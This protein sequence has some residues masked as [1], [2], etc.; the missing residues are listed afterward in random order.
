MNTIGVLRSDWSANNSLTP[1]RI[2][3]CLY[4]LPRKGKKALPSEFKF[5]YQQLYGMTNDILSF[6]NV[7]G[8]YHC[9]NA[10][11][12]H[13]YICNLI[14]AYGLI[15]KKDLVLKFDEGKTAFVSVPPLDIFNYIKDQFQRKKNSCLTYLGIEQFPT[16]DKDKDTLSRD[17]WSTNSSIPFH[18]S[19][20]EDMNEFMNRKSCLSM[21][22]MYPYLSI[23]YNNI[24]SK[25]RKKQDDL[26]RSDSTT[27][28]NLPIMQSNNKTFS[29]IYPI[30]TTTDFHFYNYSHF[31][32]DGT[33]T[34]Y[35]GDDEGSNTEDTVPTIHHSSKVRL[36][37]EANAKCSFF[38]VFNS[39]IIHSGSA[40]SFSSPTDFSTTNNPRFFTYVSRDGNDGSDAKNN[41]NKIDKVSFNFCN[42][43]KCKICKE[44]LNI[45]KTEEIVVNAYEEM[46]KRNNE[47]NKPAMKN[48]KQY[49]GRNYICGDLH[50]LGWAVYKG[51]PLCTKPQLTLLKNSVLELVERSSTGSTWMQIDKGRKICNIDRLNTGHL[52]AQ[53]SI[54]LND[55]KVFRN[56]AYEQL[57]R[58]DKFANSSFYGSSIIIHHGPCKEQEP[59][60][61]IFKDEVLVDLPST[62][63]LS[64]TGNTNKG[65]DSHDDENSNEEQ[66]SDNIDNT[67]RRKSRRRLSPSRRNKK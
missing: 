20:V 26:S 58:I 59:H 24:F 65:N 67:T 4:I 2:E 21:N 31:L 40:S 39:S 32:F 37:L 55:L 62:R 56:F 11:L 42:K 38:V 16:D 41:V 51:V 63:V 18:Q 35:K 22:K 8:Y 5:N 30:F 12:Q 44:C 6:V 61:D 10:T 60:R 43:D 46:Q 17:L 15:A 19:T 48:P 14:H 50:K 52:S 25:K 1:E 64:N 29:L 66:Q 57:R 47:I 49:H 28:L 54:A 23:D 13:N 36:R 45:Y 9:H 7:Q 3:K 33:Y 27:N 34:T 53:V